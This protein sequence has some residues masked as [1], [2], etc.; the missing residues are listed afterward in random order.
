MEPMGRCQAKEKAEA[1][2]ARQAALE[3]RKAAEAAQASP[4]RGVLGF[5][6]LG[7]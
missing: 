5:R 1:E 6:G 7:V 4:D 2:A 3:A